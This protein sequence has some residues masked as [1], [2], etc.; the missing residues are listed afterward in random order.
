MKLNY[1]GVAKDNIKGG[2]DL[3]TINSTTRLRRIK[4]I[5]EK[6]SSNMLDWLDLPFIDEDNLSRMETLGHK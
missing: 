5:Y 6:K 2:L 4:T 1:A 3:S